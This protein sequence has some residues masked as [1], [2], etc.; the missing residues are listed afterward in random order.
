MA[1]R[2]STALHVIIIEEDKNK[3]ASTLGN[4]RVTINSTTWREKY[5]PGN[6]YNASTI[7]RGGG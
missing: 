2:D 6:Y 1:R 4:I 3:T 5:W 7:E